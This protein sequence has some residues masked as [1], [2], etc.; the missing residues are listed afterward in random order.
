MHVCMD[1]CNIMQCSYVQSNETCYAMEW[2][3]A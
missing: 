1:G 3:A 2:N